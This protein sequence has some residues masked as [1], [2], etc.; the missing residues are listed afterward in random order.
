[1]TAQLS[2]KDSGAEYYHHYQNK[3]HEETYR[4]HEDVRRDYGSR[5]LTGQLMRLDYN[6]K[7]RLTHVDVWEIQL[8]H[9]LLDFLETGWN[10][11]SSAHLVQQVKQDFTGIISSRGDIVHPTYS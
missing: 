9:Q 10:E 1:M 5:L 6:K 4:G 11:W 2:D 3:A 7:D 8:F